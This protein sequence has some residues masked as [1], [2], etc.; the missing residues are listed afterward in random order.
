MS[1]ENNRKEIEVPISLLNIPEEEFAVLCDLYELAGGDDWN[2]SRPWDIS[3]SAVDDYGWEG[4]TLDDEGHVIEIDL[5]ERGLKGSIPASLFSMPYLQILDLSQNALTGK[6]EELVTENASAVN[7]KKLNL[8]N[9]LFSG[10]I[11]NSFSQLTGLKEVFLGSNR[12]EDIDYIFPWDPF[13][14]NLSY[15]TLHIAD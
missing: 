14:V 13:Y 12:L 7:L 5:S 4:L 10:T 1:E 9:N 15:Q 8:S 6:M 2:M 11:T 3:T